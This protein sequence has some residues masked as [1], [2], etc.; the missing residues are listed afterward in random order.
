MASW[1]DA[2][3]KPLF[4]VAAVALVGIVLVVPGYAELQEA[5]TASDFDGRVARHRARR[6]LAAATLDLVFAGTYG[7]LG[8]ALFL[9][10]GGRRRAARIAVVAVVLGAVCDEIENALL[11]TNL[12]RAHADERLLSAMN[13]AGWAKWQLALGWPVLLCLQPWAVARL[14]SVWRKIRD[15]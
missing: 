5:D 8:A 15:R 14:Q 3:R 9:A 11:I 6:F 2:R 12:L 7:L 1:L 4:A 13:V 10:V